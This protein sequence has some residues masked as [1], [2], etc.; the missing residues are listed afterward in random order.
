MSNM[1]SITILGQSYHCETNSRNEK[2]QIAVAAALEVISSTI[3]SSNQSSIQSVTQLTTA[4]EA[5]SGYV[6]SIEEAL[7]INNS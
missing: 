3:C 4:F 1:N 2:R 6:D 5:L 7:N